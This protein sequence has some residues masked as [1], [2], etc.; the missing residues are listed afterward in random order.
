M[1]ADL[2]KGKTL[3]FSI[4]VSPNGMVQ[5]SIGN[6]GEIEIVPHILFR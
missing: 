4:N 5:T 3:L 1:V 2:D 6:Q